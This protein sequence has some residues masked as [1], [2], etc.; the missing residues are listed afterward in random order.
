MPLLK[1]ML[2]KIEPGRCED[3]P[4]KSK[5]IN[6]KSPVT[7]EELSREVGRLLDRHT[8]AN[9]EMERLGTRIHEVEKSHVLLIEELKLLRQKVYN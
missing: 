6:P 5:P 1:K 4:N 2:K 7:Q 9:H 3:L 8:D